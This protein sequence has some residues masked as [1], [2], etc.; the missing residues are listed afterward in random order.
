ML[1][2]TEIMKNIKKFSIKYDRLDTLYAEN[3]GHREEYAALWEI[4][5]KIL[6]MSHGNAAVE[7][8]FSVNKDI[9]VENLQDIIYRVAQ[10]TGRKVNCY[11]F[12]ISNYFSAKLGTITKNILVFLW[13]L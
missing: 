12:V 5:K 4:F 11:N 3:L 1:A 9:L 8:G 6:I 2:N 13:V 7:S 10:N